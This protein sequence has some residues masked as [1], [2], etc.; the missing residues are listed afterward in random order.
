MLASAS[1]VTQ[2]P[3]LSPYPNLEINNITDLKVWPPQLLSVVSMRADACERLWVLD[4]GTVESKQLSP[5]KLVLFDLKVF[6]F[7]LLTVMTVYK[8]YITLIVY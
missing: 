7:L 5:P 1:N 8:S 2:S 4:V 6:N 3:E